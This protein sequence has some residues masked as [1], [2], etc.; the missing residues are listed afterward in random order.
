[1]SWPEIRQSGAYRGRWV[2]LDNCR[3]DAKTAE[4]VEGTIIDADDDLVELCNRIKQGENKHCAI[5]FCDDDGELS[6]PSATIERGAGSS[7]PPT[8]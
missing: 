5:L 4:P 7:F 1:M 2:A 6:R 3:Y 8:H